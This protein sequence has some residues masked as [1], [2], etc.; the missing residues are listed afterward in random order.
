MS[1]TIIILKILKK[2]LLENFLNILFFILSIFF[3]VV[4]KKTSIQRAEVVFLN[5]GQGDAILVQQDNYQ[6]LIDGGPDDSLLYEL[7]KYLPWFD[8][9]IEKVILTH[10][11]DD[12]LA[13]I[14]LLLKKYEVEEVLYADVEYDN[15][16]YK[17]LEE[18][19]SQILK[20][21]KAGDNFRYKDI[22]FS[23]L[24]PF[25]GRRYQEE[26]LN[27][28]SIVLLLYIQGYKL[29]IMGDAEQE[30]EE[31]LLE[32]EIIKNVDILKA[33]H[34]CSRSSSS[35]EFLRFTQPEISICMCGE[36]NSFNHPHYETIEKFKSLNVQYF[37]TFEEGNIR[38]RF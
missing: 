17:Y 37:I 25:E 7:S 18:N 10:P 3:V 21:V 14:M 1:N 13:G 19:Y 8:K 30:V 16:G 4:L 33:G 31:K 6:I 15:W 2:V 28:E 26:N 24:Y 23:I 38:F 20:N 34:H 36:G 12:H 5:V 29:L 22:Y 9:K 27:N 32:F 11:H 35:E